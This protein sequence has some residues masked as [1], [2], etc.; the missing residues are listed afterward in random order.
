MKLLLLIVRTY[1]RRTFLTLLCLVLAGLAEGIGISSLLPVIRIAARGQG[2]PTSDT[3]L[4]RGL[5]TALGGVGLSPTIPT[6]LALVLAGVALKA[7]LLLLANRQV[8]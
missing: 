4:E 5:A 2:G 1:P 7:V 3:A 6:L 8:G